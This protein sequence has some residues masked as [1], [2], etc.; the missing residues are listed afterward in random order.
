MVSMKMVKNLR[1]TTKRMSLKSSS[2]KF[3]TRVIPKLSS[4][5]SKMKNEL[6]I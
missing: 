2:N 3:Q 4:K 6:E 5:E 1:A